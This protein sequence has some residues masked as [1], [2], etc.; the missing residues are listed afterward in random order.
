MY[1]KVKPSKTVIQVLKTKL[2]LILR[3]LFI[4]FSF[5][6]TKIAFLKRKDFK[7]DFNVIILRLDFN[8]I[9]LYII[10]IL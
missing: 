5:T 3:E 2:P 4:L 6:F 10:Y 9:I 1:I 7:N 8:I